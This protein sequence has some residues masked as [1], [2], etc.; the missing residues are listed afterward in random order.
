MNEANFAPNDPIALLDFKA[1]K[2]KKRCVE[3]KH[4]LAAGPG[5]GSRSRFSLMTVKIQSSARLKNG[6]RMF[7]VEVKECLAN[8]V[9]AGKWDRA[10]FKSSE[11]EA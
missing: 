6:E 4:R 11:V 8:W 3:S 9:W 7:A 1:E 2:T 5:G 10:A